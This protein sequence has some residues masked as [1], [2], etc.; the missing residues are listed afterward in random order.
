MVAIPRSKA[1]HA[2][3]LRNQMKIIDPHVHLFDLTKG[4][5]HWLKADNPPFW[6]DKTII[7]KNFS[8]RALQ[9]NSNAE[10]TG[11]VHIEAGF[12]NK[13]PWREV[14][15]L[16]SVCKK[17][18]RSVACIDITLNTEKFKYHLNK[19]LTFRS[20]VGCRYIIDETAVTLLSDIQVQENLALL[21]KYQLSFDAQFSIGDSE[22]VQ[23]VITILRTIPELK[24]IINHA[25][26]PP[27]DRDSNDY[28]HWYKNME[29]IA[30]YPQCAIK[31]SGWEMADRNY[32]PNWIID[33]IK[34]CF[35]CFGE[36]RVMLASNFPLCLFYG[37]YAG[38]WQLYCE[39]LD[40][41]SQQ[42]K[43]ISYENAY[44][45]YKF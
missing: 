39:H 32:Q 37:D 33:I 5:Y 41:S 21:A 15:W 27:K 45:W 35:T 31:C 17:D 11:F 23:A 34:H 9:L 7:N 30:Q 4:D 43:L 29:F 6:S 18:F 10:L 2:I 16:E 14:Q 13:E 38:L 19:L 36:E 26:W 40:I 44:L 25:G 22:S 1:I 28:E 20:V 12:D 3:R 42:L 24:V 8:E